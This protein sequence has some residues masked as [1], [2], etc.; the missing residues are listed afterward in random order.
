[1]AL[2]YFYFQNLSVIHTFLLFIVDESKRVVSFLQLQ[3]HGMFVVF[4]AEELP[5]NFF[6]ISKASLFGSKRLSDDL[7][8]PPSF[9]SHAENGTFIALPFPVFSS[10]HFD[11]KLKL[12]FALSYF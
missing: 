4:V 5:L 2:L 1:M 3:R 10:L 12:G 7:L 9:I 11:F 6:I 8:L